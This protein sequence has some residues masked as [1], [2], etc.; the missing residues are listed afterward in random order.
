M[1]IGTMHLVRC[2]VA[3]DERLQHAVLA[4]AWGSFYMHGE[5]GAAPSLSNLYDNKVPH[6]APLPSAHRVAIAVFL[7]LFLGLGNGRAVL[8]LLP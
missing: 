5:A 1:C 6:P 8:L 4:M 7:C 2:Q 3:A